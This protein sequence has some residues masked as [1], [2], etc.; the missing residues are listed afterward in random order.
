MSRRMPVDLPA[1]GLLKG[2]QLDMGIVV[3]FGCQITQHPIHLGYESLRRARVSNNVGQCGP[4][5][6]FLRCAVRKSDFYLWHG[7]LPKMASGLSSK[8]KCPRSRSR[9][10][11]IPAVPPTFRPEGNSAALSLRNGEYRRLCAVLKPQ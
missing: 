1:F 6:V 10:G 2:H 8:Q 5:G 9:D 11:A 4:L 3:E 7:R